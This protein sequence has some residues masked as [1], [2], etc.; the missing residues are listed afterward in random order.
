MVDI[1]R[2]IPILFG[3]VLKKSAIFKRWFCKICLVFVL[4]VNMWV[5][6]ILNLRKANVSI[7]P[8]VGFVPN[9]IVES[10]VLALNEL[11]QI[12]PLKVIS[13]DHICAFDNVHLVSLVSPNI[14]YSEV[15]CV[16]NNADSPLL[17]PTDANALE[18]LD[19]NGE[20]MDKIVLNFDSSSTHLISSSTGLNVS[21]EGFDVM[22]K[23]VAS[24]SNPILNSD[25]PIE[26]MDVSNSVPIFGCIFSAGFDAWWLLG[27]SFS[28]G[29][30]LGW[31]VVEAL[32]LFQRS[33]FLGCSLAGLACL[34]FF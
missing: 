34:P 5:I 3:L 7:Q 24:S 33:L 22:G 14:V 13:N 15:V 21:N 10:G 32:L 31:L 8:D 29:G 9:L 19:S 30:D 2:H 28:A 12:L 25:L 27:C 26:G 6:E 16:N 23:I 20:K 1:F 17:T 18:N 4:T 11:E